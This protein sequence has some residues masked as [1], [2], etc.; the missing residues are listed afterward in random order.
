V[1]LRNVEVALFARLR[2]Q[3][4]QAVRDYFLPE[5]VIDY[6]FANLSS[7]LAAMD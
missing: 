6:R 5:A 3:Q 7:A 1:N 2:S 4:P